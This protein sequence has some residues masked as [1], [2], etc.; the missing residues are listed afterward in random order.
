MS[1]NTSGL[2]TDDKMADLPVIEKMEKK[3][4]KTSLSEIRKIQTFFE[5][6][7]RKLQ[8]KNLLSEETNQKMTL[9]K[10]K[11]CTSR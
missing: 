1:I 11:L 7:E 2:N 10:M 8:M 3:V 5:N 6:F 4:W 9:L